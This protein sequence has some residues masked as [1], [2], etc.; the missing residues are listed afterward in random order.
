[1]GSINPAYFLA[2]YL[3]KVDIREYGDK[4]AGVTNAS[5]LLGKGPA[6]F[7]AIFDISK[8]IL[9]MGIAYFIGAPLLFVYLAGI[10][11]IVGHIFPFYLNFR[12]G[13]GAAT[14]IGLLLTFLFLSIIECRFRFY[15]YLLFIH[16]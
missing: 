3:K 13:Q 7:I 11:A 6:V 8:G 15:F 2:K 4:N 12:G 9:S 14:T 10:A 1:M 16:W 5:H